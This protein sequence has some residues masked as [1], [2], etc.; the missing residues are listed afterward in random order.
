MAIL[1]VTCFSQ[2]GQRDLQQRRPLI[3][4]GLAMVTLFGFAIN[5]I[6]QRELRVYELCLWLA[7][8]G[9]AIVLLTRHGRQACRTDS[10][11]PRWAYLLLS[12]ALFAAFFGLYVDAAYLRYAENEMDKVL[13]IPEKLY[14]GFVRVAFEEDRRSGDIRLWVDSIASFTRFGI[15]MAIIVLGGFLGVN[16]GVFPWCRA[17]FYRFMVF[18][19]KIPVMALVPIIFILANQLPVEDAGEYW[20][21]GVIVLGVMPTVCLDAYGRASAVPRELIHKAQSLGATEQEICYRVVLPQVIPHMLDCVRLNIKVVVNLLIA[22][23]ALEAM[24]GLGYRIFIM[25]RHTAMDVIIPYVL[26]MT[27]LAFLADY[28]LQW[29]KA[30]RYPWAGQN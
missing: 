23:E 4:V 21:I 5:S 26:Y 28:A 10:V 6:V 14:A 22:A 30:K 18:F 8:T 19:D 12:F 15:A 2:Q 29:I 17:I 1:A 9:I 25:R 7:G 13:P 11:P 20:K 16:M 24:A 3:V 27:I